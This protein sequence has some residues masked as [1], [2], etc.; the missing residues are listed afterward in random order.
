MERV[1]LQLKLAMFKMTSS[2]TTFAGASGNKYVIMH[3][4]R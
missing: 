1:E 4:H 3:A 2:A